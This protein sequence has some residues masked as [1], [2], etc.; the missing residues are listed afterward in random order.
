MRRTSRRSLGVVGW[1]CLSL[2]GV[3]HA[4]DATLGKT[5][6]EGRCA[7][8]HGVAGKGD[9]PAG[10]ALKPPPTSF[11]NAAVWKSLTP[12]A[13]KSIIE[14]GTPGTGMIA[15]KAALTTEQIAALVAYL[16]T[17]KPAQ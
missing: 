14:N 3:V 13:M 6:Y 5:V 7:F 12:E 8:C 1:V 9:G 11:T 15:F 10:A 17:F 4:E 2:L 16:Q